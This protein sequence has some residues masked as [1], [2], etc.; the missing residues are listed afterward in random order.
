MFQAK[1]S[2]PSRILWDTVAFKM[3][4]LGETYG[5]IGVSAY[6]SLAISGIGHYSLEPYATLRS[7]HHQAPL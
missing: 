5:R 6:R 7:R 2:V 1:S 3:G 4:R